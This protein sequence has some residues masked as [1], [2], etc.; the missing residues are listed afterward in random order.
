MKINLLIIQIQKLGLTSYKKIMQIFHPDGKTPVED[1]GVDIFPVSHFYVG[2]P[3][4]PLWKMRP[5]TIKRLI[6]SRTGRLSNIRQVFLTGE[7]IY[8]HPGTGTLRFVFFKRYSKSF[9]GFNLAY[10]D[11]RDAFYII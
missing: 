4:R 2:T 5:S 7:R 11:V 3:D 6:I 9:P 10:N 8:A 1:G